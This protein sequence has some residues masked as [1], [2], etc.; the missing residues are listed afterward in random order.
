MLDRSVALTLSQRTMLFSL[1]DTQ[2]LL[3]RTTER[4]TTGRDVNKVVDDA[5]AYFRA[6]ELY[7]TSDDFS[8]YKDQIDQGISSI[9]AAMSGLDAVEELLQQMKG[10]AES[11]RSQSLNER[12]N[13]TREFLEIGD[14]I[15]ALVEDASYSG[16]NLLNRSQDVLDVRFSNHTSSRLLLDSF[17]YNAT[18][19]GEA[20]SLFSTAAFKSNH[21][22]AAFSVAFANDNIVTLAN[23]ETIESTGFSSIGSENSAMALVDQLVN[24]LDTLINRT[25]ANAQEM[26]H[27]VG[28]LQTRFQYS[29]GI[30]ERLDEGGDKLTLADLNE[31]GANMVA[32]RS[33]YEIG[34]QSLSVSGDFHRKLVTLIRR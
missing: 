23:G 4:V 1:K 19:A 7:H 29:Q 32:L 6:R 30:M 22:F 17:N 12:V 24:T 8:Y 2:D 14:Q 34:V 31:E 18:S 5:V 25:R 21:S 26:S 10:I 9:T 15:S 3:E 33:R 20:R 27:A 16:Y 13:A 11:T 28:L